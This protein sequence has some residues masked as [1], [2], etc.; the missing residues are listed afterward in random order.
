MKIGLLLT[1]VG[2]YGRQGFYNTQEIG[3]AKAL[4]PL[5]DRVLIYRPFLR[6][7]SRP[8]K[9]PAWSQNIELHSIP[10]WGLGSN[11]LFSLKHL[12]PTLDALIYFSD[13][14]L[15]VHAVAAWARKHA[16]AL[17]PYIGVLESHSE[18]A[19]KRWLMN[20]C[21]RR[22][23]RQ[24]RRLHCFAK[25]PQVRRRLREMGVRQADLAPVGLDTT[26]LHRDFDRVPRETL[27]EKY[28]Y[29]PQDR[30]VLFVGRL[31][32]E[33]RPVALV[34]FFKTLSGADSRFR[35]LMV[36]TGPLEAQTH[37]RARALGLEQQIRFLPQVPNCHMWELYRLSEAFV[38]WNRQEIFGMALLEAMYYGCKVVAWHA[39]GPDLIIEDG[40]SGFLVDSE[41]EALRRLTEHHPLGNAPRQRVLTRFTWDAA[42][43]SFMQTAGK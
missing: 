21:F 39:P 31:V 2:D 14:Q 42:A 18:C 8:G 43:H 29:G 34:E 17:Y 10:A 30:V 35:L 24:Y 33:K 11:G 7:Q 41:A 6:R 4:A 36:G 13:T 38:N 23:L 9:D 22:A 12:D 5:A 1:T 15:M 28:G 27:K 32:E 25:T 19:W 26:L 3:L 16:V 20:V 37:L 40:A